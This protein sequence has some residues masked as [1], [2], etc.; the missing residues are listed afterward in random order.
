MPTRNYREHGRSG[1]SN[2]YRTLFLLALGLQTCMD[3]SGSFR[4]PNL[5]KQGFVEEGDQYFAQEGFPKRY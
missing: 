3:F 4:D 1:S 2:P 5:R